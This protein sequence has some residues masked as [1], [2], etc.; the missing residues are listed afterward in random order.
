MLC[1][2]PLYQASIAF[3]YPASSIPLHHFPSIWAL[4]LPG[5]VICD[6]NYILGR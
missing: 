6:I 2:I 1:C 3:N 4:Q 5:K